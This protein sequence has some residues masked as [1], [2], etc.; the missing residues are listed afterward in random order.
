MTEEDMSQAITKLNVGMALKTASRMVA[1][2][3]KSKFQIR[4]IC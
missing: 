4:K 2:A 1:L 3:K